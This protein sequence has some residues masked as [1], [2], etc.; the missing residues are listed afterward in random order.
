[1]S[2]LGRLPSIYHMARSHGRKRYYQ[3][4]LDP[5][6]AEAAE[7]EAE[8]QGVRVTALMRDWIYEKLKQLL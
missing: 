3:V 5:E 7:K 6:Q 2:E 8:H 4:L 1:M